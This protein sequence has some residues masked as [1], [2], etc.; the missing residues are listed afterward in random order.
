MKGRSVDTPFLLVFLC[1]AGFGMLI[2]T[3]AAL[4]LLAN[5]SGANFSSVAATQFLLGFLLGGVALVTLSRMDYKKWRPYTPYFFAGAVLL[6]LL[7][8]VPG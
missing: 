3:S 5:D 1:L 2:F 6:T 8:F 4:G 7:T